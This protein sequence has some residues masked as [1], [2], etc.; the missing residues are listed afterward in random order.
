MPAGRPTDGSAHVDRLS[1]HTQE[2]QRLKAILE[3]ISG[4]RSV[5]SACEE[6]HVSEARFH[7]L[8]RQALQ[9]ALDGL[10]PKSPGRPKRPTEAGPSRVEELEAE[11][12]EL[13]I[14]LEAARIRT[15]IAM[16]MPHLVRKTKPITGS[17]KNELLRKLKQLEDTGEL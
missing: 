12:Q 2:K 8:R 4:E 17:K 10:V 16:V 15:E 6:L 13:R 1:G 7:E 11:V 14:E 3:V 5:P 9:S